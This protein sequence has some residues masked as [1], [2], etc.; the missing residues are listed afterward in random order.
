MG[1]PQPTLSVL[2]PK[3]SSSRRH[4][5]FA[6]IIVDVNHKKEKPAEEEKISQDKNIQIYSRAR[7]LLRNGGPV[8][9][10]C[11]WM[12]LN[13]DVATALTLTLFCIT[14]CEH[15]SCQLFGR[16]FR[17]IEMNM[18]RGPQSR[19]SQKRRRY[20]WYLFI[21]VLCTVAAFPINLLGSDARRVSETFSGYFNINEN[22]YRH[23]GPINGGARAFVYCKLKIKRSG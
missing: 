20:S 7:E 10:N 15:F 17:I 16:W 1:P 9:T 14:Q 18:Y 12:G 22:I 6:T 2:P 3:W 23:T 5:R 13:V 19:K 21:F 11:L 4:A 8:H